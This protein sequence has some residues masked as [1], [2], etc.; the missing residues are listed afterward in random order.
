MATSVAWQTTATVTASAV[1]YYTVPSASTAA[2]GSYARD[3]VLTNGGATTFSVGAG[4]AASSATT[5]ASFALPP[6]GTVILTQCQV[7]PST[8]IYAIGPGTLSVGWATNV[9]YF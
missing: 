7:P 6:G 4:T 1:A 2:Y 9:S 5:A 3:L 8:I